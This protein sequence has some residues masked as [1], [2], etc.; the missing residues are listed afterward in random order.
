MGYSGLV[1]A[2]QSCHVQGFFYSEGRVFAVTN[3]WVH[4]D[5][6]YEPVRLVGYQPVALHGAERREVREPIYEVI[7][8]PLAEL[9]RRGGPLNDPGDTRR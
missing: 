9:N 3:L 8:E 1:R 2:K 7:T 4:P 6:P 5:D